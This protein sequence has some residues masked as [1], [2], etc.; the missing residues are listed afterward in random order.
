MKKSKKSTTEGG[1]RLQECLKE[2]RMT[3]IELAELTNYS[4]QHINNIITGKRNMSRD[5]AHR[6]AQ[7]LEIQEGYLL[8]ETAYKTF[9]DRL[10]FEVKQDSLIIDQLE[11]LIFMMGYKKKRKFW[12]G[13]QLMDCINHSLEELS[14]F[15]DHTTDEELEA[16]N[17]CYAELILEIEKPN[18]QTIVCRECDYR[19]ALLEIGEY[20]KFKLKYI[21]N[22][23]NFDILDSGSNSLEPAEG[24]I[25]QI[26]S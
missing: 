12:N 20:I 15:K 26:F 21:S 6:F 13:W 4:Q 22:D 25:V 24:S 10:S 9:S 1:N 7:V 8:C 3:Q 5:A 18:H 14:D 2:A 23:F 11:Q 19:D 16:A 17:K